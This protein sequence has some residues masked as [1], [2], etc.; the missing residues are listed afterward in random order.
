MIKVNDAYGLNI[1][2]P[3]LY[4]YD[5]KSLRESAELSRFKELKLIKKYLKDGYEI[6]FSPNPK[7]NWIRINN[8]TFNGYTRKM[9]DNILKEVQNDL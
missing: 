1:T 2:H 8:T 4:V 9:V 7:T 6:Q 5:K 3:D